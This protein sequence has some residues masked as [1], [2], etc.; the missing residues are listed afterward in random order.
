MA[1]PETGPRRRAR[2]AAFRV[3]FQADVNGDTVGET[4]DTRRGEEHLADDQAVMVQ[5]VVR[6]L[7]GRSAEIDASL[8]AAVAE[9]LAH[10]GTPARV[11]IDEAIEIAR[12][13]GSAESG[14]FVNGVLDRIAHALR[15][16]EFA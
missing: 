2:E 6:A 4:W 16:A 7:A 14:G 15:P 8:R 9:L 11:V 3:A 13:Y 5:D 10:P 1:R 12:E